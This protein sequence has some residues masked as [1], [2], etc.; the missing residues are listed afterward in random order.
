MQLL[1][2]HYKITLSASVILKD[3][4][5]DFNLTPVQEAIIPA[6]VFFFYAI[7]KFTL[8]SRFNFLRV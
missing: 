6:I 3:M 4:K 2:S 8:L 5:C 7:G 1:I